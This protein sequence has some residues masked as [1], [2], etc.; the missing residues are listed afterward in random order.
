MSKY[1]KTDVTLQKN[2]QL[3][4]K[5][6][7]PLVQMMDLMIKSNTGNEEMFDLATQS[8][9]LLAFA[10]RDLSNVRRKMLKPA[11]H[12]K[13]QKLCAPHVQ[14]TKQ[15]FGDDLEKQLKSISE[16]KKIG[17]KIGLSD[18]KKHY[19]SRSSNWQK[20]RRSNH[21]LYHRQ[22]ARRDN[23]QRS[24]R[25]KKPYPTSSSAQKPQK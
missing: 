24:G 16:Q 23:Y 13:Y 21:F 10:H 20:G 9:Q 3:L 11:V 25:Q 6:M 4:T 22:S 19:H 5:G 18:K 14:I 7:I 1:K 15:L 12:S 8:I 2:Q 17:N